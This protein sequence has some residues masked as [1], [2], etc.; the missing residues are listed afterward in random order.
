MS[1]EEIR[2]D[3]VRHIRHCA[4]RHNVKQDEVVNVVKDVVDGMDF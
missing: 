1:K 4:M 2:A 3:I